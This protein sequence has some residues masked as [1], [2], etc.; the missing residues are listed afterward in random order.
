M[1]FV[2]NPFSGNFD[3]AGVAIGDPVGNGT[4]GGLLYVNSS[5]QL[6]Q[7]P[8]KLFW[9]QPNSRLGVGTA[10]PQSGIHVGSQ[11]HTGGTATDAIVEGRLMLGNNLSGVNFTANR[12]IDMRYA[13]TAAAG[14]I[15]WN[16]ATTLTS[17]AGAFTGLTLLQISVTGTP[18]STSGTGLLRG[19]FFTSTG[20]APTGVTFSEAIGG[21]F[22]CSSTTSG[23]TITKATGM[24][25]VTLGDTASST[26]PTIFGI[27]SQIANRQASSTL[28]AAFAVSQGTGGFSGS[29]TDY[30]AFNNST[31]VG[32]SASVTNWSVVRN[33]I[34]PTNPTG[35]KLFLNNTANIASVTRGN[36]S[37]G[38]T[39]LP[40]ALLHLAASPGSANNAPLKFT[41]SV[42]LVTPEAG[43]VEVEFD[44][45]YYTLALSAT[46]HP[47]V[48]AESGLTAGR[49]PFA[50]AS[51]NGRLSDDANF[52]YDPSLF[53]TDG[54]LT[55]LGKLYVVE[56]GYSDDGYSKIQFGRTSTDTGS[57]NRACFSALMTSNNASAS[58]ANFMGFDGGINV[59]GSGNLTQNGIGLG[60]VG[61]RGSL[62]VNTSATIASGTALNG[63]VY[64][65]SGNPTITNLYCV[66]ARWDLF[67]AATITNTYGV[68]VMDPNTNGVR[69]TNNYGLYIAD[70]VGGVTLNYA[71]YSN[72]GQSVHK[73]KMSVGA[74]TDPTEILDLFGNLK[75]PSGGNIV[76][77]TT[78]GTKIGT[79][80]TQKLGFWNTAPIVQPATG[81]AA[82]TFTANTS[83]I[84]DD[85]ATF[86]GYTLGNVVKALRNVGLLA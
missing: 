44:D 39:S 52:L 73:G 26:T 18:T 12:I 53:S 81:G 7:D 66:A 1:A 85:S 8:T 20:N 58:S 77:D 51:N 49:V 43:A 45:I 79:G 42:R 21:Q 72:G 9:D 62:E 67:G 25:A 57:V 80:T 34:A 10:S 60:A 48:L 37:V 82:S 33:T 40:T 65:H 68:Y 76:T 71:I 13:P 23:G 11:T 41:D 46:R 78:N 38:Q 56:S 35:N 27:E 50:S 6:A 24:R 3:V 61:L 36:L 64:I 16:Y 69:P 28:T 86:D 55:L 19:F 15:Q 4:S 29:C 22:Q 70:Q 5:G 17:V 47:F 63:L 59:T 84:A 74:V 75:F 31:S 2:F 32:D 30:A 54:A 83:G 14:L